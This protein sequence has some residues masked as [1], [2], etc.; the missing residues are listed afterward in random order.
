[1]LKE[2]CP[3]GSD[4]SYFECCG[5]YHKGLAAENALLLMRSRYTAYAL[6]LADYIMDTTHPQSPHFQA[7]RNQWKK[8][9]LSF[10]HETSFEKLEIVDFTDGKSEAYVTF[11]AFLNQGG[12]K[13]QLHERSHF[14][15]GS[16]R[17]YYR[18]GQV[19]IIPL[20]N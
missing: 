10:S 7:N 6:G 16:G 18:G 19:N 13:V 15:K 20:P 1:M 2:I 9:I 5:R 14:E 12:K 8:E 3:C 4:K 11:I 17:W